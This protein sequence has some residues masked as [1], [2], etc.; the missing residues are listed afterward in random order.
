M[1][2][3]CVLRSVAGNSQDGRTGDVRIDVVVER[4]S[5]GARAGVVQRSHSPSSNALVGEEDFEMWYKDLYNASLDPFE[6]IAAQQR[7]KKKT[8]I[9]ALQ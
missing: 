1:L 5:G 8:K 3:N 6:R 2:L 4:G 9:Y 7:H